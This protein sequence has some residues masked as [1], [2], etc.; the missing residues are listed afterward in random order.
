[1]AGHLRMECPIQ[2]EPWPAI[3]PMNAHIQ[4]RWASMTDAHPGSHENGK[5]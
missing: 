1:M 2:I 5:K 4:E 3:W